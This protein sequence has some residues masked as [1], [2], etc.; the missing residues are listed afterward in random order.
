[1]AARPATTRAALSAAFIRGKKI[2][3]HKS[4]SSFPIVCMKVLTQGQ[5]LAWSQDGGCLCNPTSCML[6]SVRCELS[7]INYVAVSLASPL[8]LQLA[9]LR[10]AVLCLL[11]KVYTSQR[12]VHS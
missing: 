7:L 2:L 6:G 11:T 8:T 12:L 9:I 5:P 10:N 4:L 3:L 1:M